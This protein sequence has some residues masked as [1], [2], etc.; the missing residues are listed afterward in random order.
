VYAAGRAGG[1]AYPDETTFVAHVTDA[2]DEI[3]DL[4]HRAEKLGQQIAAAD[5]AVTDLRKA[6][7][8]LAR[9]DAMPVKTGC[10]GCYEARTAAI[11]AAP[12]RSPTRASGSPFA[13]SPRSS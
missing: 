9:A 6:R 2:E 4:L 3:A 1:R 8:A 5:A 12:Q 13:S 10:D 7:L 11:E